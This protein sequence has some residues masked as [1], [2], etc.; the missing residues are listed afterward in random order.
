MK[1]DLFRFTAFGAILIIALSSCSNSGTA[2]ISGVLL[3]S[4][5]NPKPIVGKEIFFGHR[6][7]P[8]LSAITDQNGAFNIQGEYNIKIPSLGS[9]EGFMLWVD[10]GFGYDQLA[11]QFPDQVDLDTIYLTNWVNVILSLNVTDEA[12]YSSSDTITFNS[13]YYDDFHK[14]KYAGPFQNH[15]VL[16][17]FRL[18]VDPHMGYPSIEAHTVSWGLQCL[19][20]GAQDTVIPIPYTE[21]QRNFP[22]RDYLSFE[23]VL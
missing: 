21:G 17:T 5:D 12:K 11:F 20:N 4:C 23:F 6:T 15:Q 2:N 1:I 3:E 7:T 8:A 22:C 14:K 16:D 9:F 10:N 13:L 19:L 18:T